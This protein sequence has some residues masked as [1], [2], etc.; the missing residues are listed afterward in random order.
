MALESVVD[1]VYT[2]ESDVWSYGVLFWEIVTL[3]KLVN[4]FKLMYFATYY[5]LFIVSRRI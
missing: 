1:N 4:P 5:V 3:G 2:T